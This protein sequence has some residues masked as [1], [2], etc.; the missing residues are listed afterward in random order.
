MASLAEQYTPWIK[1][2]TMQMYNNFRGYYPYEDLLS[3]AY[4]AAA[5]S[6]AG[7]NPEM[8]KYPAYIKP[9]V[10]GAI[11]RSVSNITTKEHRMLLKMYKF[12]DDYVESKG[13]IPAQ[14]IIMKH[15]GIKT[16]EFLSLIDT[17][18]SIT[19]V[20][21]DNI[22]EEETAVSSNILEADE[23]DRMMA[24]VRTLSKAQ[25]QR[26]ARFLEDPTEPEANIKDILGIIRHR[27][28]IEEGHE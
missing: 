13:K 20:S 6:E 11:I 18:A 26:V 24:I 16:K 3:T 15:L 10:Q 27:L 21:T 4:L 22:S 23:Y 19:L 7:Y 9:R 12:I 1:K 2:I 17:D 14:H 25:Q 5:E 8:G 28:N